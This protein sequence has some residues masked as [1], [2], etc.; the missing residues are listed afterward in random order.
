AML[1]NWMVSL[2][3]IGAMM[4][5]DVIGKV[6]AMWMPIMLFFYME[7]HRRLLCNF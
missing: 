3:V 7:T 2:G 1:C 4:S 6:I 5:K